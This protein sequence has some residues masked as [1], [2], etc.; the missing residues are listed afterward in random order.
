MA[1]CANISGSSLLSSLMANPV[2]WRC[3]TYARDATMA[4]ALF[5][6]VGLVGRN[7]S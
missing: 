4:K 3:D 6:C 7:D 5:V 1:Y 2:G